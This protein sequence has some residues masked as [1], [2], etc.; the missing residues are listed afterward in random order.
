MS[1]KSDS[2][3]TRLVDRVFPRMPDFYGLL[4]EQCDILVEAMDA[5]VEFMQ[6]G[7][8]EKGLKVR[9]IEKRA[10][11]LKARNVE[12]LNRAFATP[13]DREDIYDAVVALDMGINYAKTTVRE[14]EALGLAPDEFMREMAAEY[15]NAAL[16]LQQGFRK[17]TSNSI[18]GEEDAR[19]ARKT[20][21]N[22]EKIYRRA[23]AHLFDT[24]E[25]AARL[26]DDETDPHV[27]TMHTVVDMFKRRE[28]YRHMSNGADRLAD[29]AERLHDII[30]KIS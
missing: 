14:L 21:R 24:D 12:I 23:L 22:T 7:S 11:R 13:M 5:L 19:A 29:A 18:E 4:N 16:A 26:K 15:K 25:M 30:V 20:E 3:V 1:G 28:V 17:L 8:E 2:V 6:D 10:D 9:Q 27:Q